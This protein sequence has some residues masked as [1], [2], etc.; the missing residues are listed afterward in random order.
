MNPQDRIA[1]FGGHEVFWERSVLVGRTLLECQKRF[2][3]TMVDLSQVSSARN[4][5]SSIGER[6]FVEHCELPG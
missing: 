4:E 2:P 3:E 6:L 5:P 1:A